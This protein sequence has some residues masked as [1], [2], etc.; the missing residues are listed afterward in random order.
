MPTKIIASTLVM[1]SLAACGSK[2]ASNGNF[3][4]AINAHL[5]RDCITIQPIIFSADV[6]RY[7]MTVSMV[8][9]NDYNTQAQVDQNNAEKT[10]TLDLLVKSGL[11]SVSEGTKK[12]TPLFSKQERIVPTKV[13]TL[14]EMGKKA[15][16]KETGTA[17]CVG[18]YKVDDIVRFTEPNQAMGQ[19]MSQVSFTASPV[20]VAD[21]A[22]NSA[23]QAD[24]GLEKRLAAHQQHTATMVLASDGWIEAS[25]FG[26]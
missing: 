5:S 4:K 12:E 2:S 13:F 18:H 24:F 20:D 9:K 15:L 26:R 7:P 17:M 19:T 6:Q 8:Q 3:E 1:L 21:W 11:L 16:V 22:K 14:T 25:D 10:K 23:L